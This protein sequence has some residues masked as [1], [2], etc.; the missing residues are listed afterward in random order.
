MGIFFTAVLSS[1]LVFL[2]VS[3]IVRNLYGPAPHEDNARWMPLV[4]IVSI[5]CLL[6]D[7]CA[8][9]FVAES[10]SL[11][12]SASLVAVYPMSCSI[13]PSRW[14]RWM[15]VV[16]SVLEV[17]CV[18][19][20]MV[21]THTSLFQIP[22]DLLSYIA[23]ISCSLPVIVFVIGIYMRLRDVKVVMRTCSVWTMV[24]LSVDAVYA[25]IILMYALLLPVITPWIST[26]LLSSVLI[27]LSIRIRNAS[28]FVLLVSH[29]RRIVESMRLSQTECVSDNPG[30]DVLYDN[31]Y[32]RILRY[33]ESARPYLNTELT[34]SDIVEVI[35]TNKVYVSRAISH[36][37]GRNFCQFVNYHRV[38]YA[39][40]QFRANP[41]L[42]VGELAGSCGFNSTTSFNNAFRLYMGEKPSEWCRKERARLTKK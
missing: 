9:A 14:S 27:A 20:V 3:Q 6:T 41:Q 39:V 23:V 30:A 12:V 24:C 34:I 38:S 4:L 21:C 11:T 31:I 37:T 19:C 15:A 13:V 16:A 33:F 18:L 36:C 10:I 28:V 8:G 26:I 25:V 35:Y 1:A 7:L 22:S 32:E 29:E 5:C 40:E 2:A 42:K 17:S